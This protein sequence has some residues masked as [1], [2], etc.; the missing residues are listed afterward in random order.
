MINLTT[1]QIATIVGVKEIELMALRHELE[2][3]RARIAELEKQSTD[4][5]I[6]DMS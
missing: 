4:A 5:P 2:V 1:D 3:A 6:A